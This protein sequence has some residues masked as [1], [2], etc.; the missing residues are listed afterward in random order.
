MLLN[1]IG[2]VSKLYKQDDMQIKR[3]IA[4]SIYP[5]KLVFDGKGF[6]LMK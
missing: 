2:N 4:S 6:K 3:S 5:K 1:V